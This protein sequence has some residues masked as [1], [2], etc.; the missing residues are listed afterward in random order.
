ML[1]TT[2]GT[3]DMPLTAV[4]FATDGVENFLE[5][6][7]KTDTQDFLGKMEGFAVQGVRGMNFSFESIVL[8]V[9]NVLCRFCKKPSAACF[10]YSC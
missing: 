9:N 7:L 6:A 1:F 3:T 2:R 5:G 4:A 10:S 8:V